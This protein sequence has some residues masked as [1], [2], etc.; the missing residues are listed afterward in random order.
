VLGRLP[1]A[2]V[3]VGRHGDHRLG[4]L[5][6]QVLLAD[7][8]HLLEDVGG[9]LRDGEHLV[10]QHHPHVV[11]RPLDDAVRHGLDRGAD[12]GRAPLAADQPLGGVDR[13]LGVRDR[14]SLRDVTDQALA[15]LG[16]GHHRRGGLVAAPVG[17]DHRRP[18]LHD[19]DAG[20]GGPQVDA[21]HPL[22]H[23]S[24]LPPAPGRTAIARSLTSPAVVMVP[25]PARPGGYSAARA[26]RTAARSLWISRTRISLALGSSRARIKI[27]SASASLRAARYTSA[28]TRAYDASS[29]RKLAAFLAYSSASLKRPEASAQRAARRK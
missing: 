1:L 18:V 7:D 25:S 17:D 13:V 9:H 10:A 2:V 19:G 22:A 21:D 20:V 24:A 8:L 6:P 11:V 28:R 4:D 3:E 29:E 27:S 14:L 23:R 26:A 15:V 16:D 5:L 12:R